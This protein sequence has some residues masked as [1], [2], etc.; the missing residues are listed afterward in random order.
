[1]RREILSPLIGKLALVAFI[2]L[3]ASIGTRAEEGTEEQRDAC[4]P[5]AFRLCASEI[6]DIPRITACMEANK[7]RLSPRCRVFFEPAGTNTQKPRPTNMRHRKKPAPHDDP[8][9]HT[10]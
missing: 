4:T 6:P 9:H 10:Q 7:E 1:M 2:S 8:H 3:A 5:D